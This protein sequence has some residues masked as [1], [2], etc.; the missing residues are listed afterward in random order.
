MTAPIELLSPA[1]TAEVGMEA[2]LHGADAVYI[3]GPAYGARSA[4]ANSI[5]DIARLCSFAHSYGARVYVTLNTIIYDHELAEAERLIWQVYR[6]GADALIVQDLG[7]LRLHLPPLAL[8][9]STQTDITTPERARLLAEAGFTRLVVAR[10]LTLTQIAAIREQ[11]GLPIEAFVH[12]ALCVSYSGRCYASQHCF[13]RSANRGDCAQFCRLPFTLKDAAGRVVSREQHLLSL[14]DMNRTEELEG[15]MDAGVQSF[16]IEGRLK[17]VTYVKNI[18]AWY[19]QQIDRILDRRTT[20]YHRAS[21]GHT[22]LS[23]TP[24][25]ARSFNR[26]FTPYFIHG[27]SS[28]P[29][30][31]LF[32]PKATGPVVGRIQQVGRKSFTLH[33]SHGVPPIKAGDGLCYVTAEGK[34]EGFRVNRVDADNI[35]PQRMPHLAPGMMLHRNLD[36]EFQTRLARPTATRTLNVDITLRQ[37]EDGYVIDMA[38]EMGA[39]ASVRFEAEHQEALSP[40][41][42]A[43]RN[44]LSRLGG[45]IHSVRVIHLNLEGEHFIPASKLAAWRRTAYEELCRAGRMLMRPE[46]PGVVNHE[47]LSKIFAE[48]VQSDSPAL[49]QAALP[50]NV[51]NRQAREFYAAHGAA[52]V[53]AAFELNP[54][55]KQVAPTVLMTCKHCIRRTLGLCLKLHPAK[56]REVREPLTL[57]LADGRCFRLH[58]DCR[59]CEMQVLTADGH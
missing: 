36:A 56:A 20:D 44:L 28:A 52:S 49:K 19:R 15:M 42:E 2:I 4:A 13:R 50:Q 22:T 46:R 1:R 47:R 32:S 3:G 27:L 33:L 26:G 38:D 54:A 53:P 59:A 55:E 41:Q 29:K 12:G 51:A 58:F 24:D 16:K 14:P 48:A 25:P 7:L 6:A 37:V 31:T 17:D 34:L 45:T 40:Q 18:T 35:M 11:T 21:Y 9:A 8:H 23:F 5:D 30:A 57:H 43:Q 39:A 10:E